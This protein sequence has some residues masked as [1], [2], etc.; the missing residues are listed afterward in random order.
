MFKLSDEEIEA[1]R[2]ALYH[3][4]NTSSASVW[5]DLAYHES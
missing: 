5:Y 4:G 2:A 1:S 3:Y